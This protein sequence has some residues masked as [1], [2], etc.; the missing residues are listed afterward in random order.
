MDDK[1]RKKYL[2]EIYRRYASVIYSRVYFL[3]REHSESKDVTHDTFIS[4]MC[5]KGLPDSVASPLRVL[6]KIATCKAVD[7]LRS[8]SRWSGVCGALEILEDDSSQ[9]RQDQGPSYGGEL[10][11]IEMQQDLALLTKEEKPKTIVVVFLYVVEEYT[12]EEIAALEGISRRTVYNILSKFG[13]R[14]RRRMAE[15]D[16]GD[17]A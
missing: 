9:E 14:A 3:L 6:Y 13:E 15:F 8:R 1:T 11:R 7:R 10:N 12:M 16:G 5:I 4:F 2:E 17:D